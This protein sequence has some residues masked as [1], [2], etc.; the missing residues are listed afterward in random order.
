MPSKPRFRRPQFRS[1]EA[2]VYR[3]LYRD[4]RWRGPL[5]IRQQALLRDLFQCQRCECI[6]VTG[7][8]NH[9]RAAN[10]NHKV[11][12]KGSEDLFFDLNNTET[13]C[14]RCHSGLIQRE[15]ARGYMIG[16]DINGRPVDTTHPWNRR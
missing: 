14:Q 12:H 7:Q 8:R 10:V 16:S 5:G 1:P 2:E 15:E 13:V 11:P 9:P 6:V 4:P 3:R